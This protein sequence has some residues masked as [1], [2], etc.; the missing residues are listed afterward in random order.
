MPLAF[1]SGIGSLSV[2]LLTK[3]VMISAPTSFA[4][5]P[6][7]PSAGLKP[8]DPTMPLRAGKPGENSE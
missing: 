6:I 8:V 5:S 1:L 3:Y 4:Y 7:R 2:T